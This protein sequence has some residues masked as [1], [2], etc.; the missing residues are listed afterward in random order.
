M[1]S[2]APLESKKQT[3][4]SGSEDQGTFEPE[5]RQLFS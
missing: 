2:A 1:N 3:Y 4:E 5:P